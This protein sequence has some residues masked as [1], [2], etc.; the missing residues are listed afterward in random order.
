MRCNV[1]PQTSRIG[2]DTATVST[3]PNPII[4]PLRSP[5]REDKHQNDDG[6]RFDEVP[7]ERGDGIVH[8]V[9]LEEDLFGM[10]PCRNVFHRFGQPG[11]DGLAHIGN[12]GRRLHRH[13][14]G[15]RRSAVHEKS[16]ALRFRKGPF[17]TGDVSDTHRLAI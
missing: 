3:S 13:T 6:D 11:I 9:G 14:D 7:H 10:E 12:D 4:S 5:H 1:V 2:K 16:V 17:D 15:E 8:L